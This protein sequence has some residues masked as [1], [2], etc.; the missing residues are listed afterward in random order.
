MTKEQRAR[1]DTLTDQY[2]FCFIIQGPFHSSWNEK[3]M[4]KFIA[5]KHPDKYEFLRLTADTTYIFWNPK[6]GKVTAA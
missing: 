4:D 6:D 2:K 3:R 5:E 1:L